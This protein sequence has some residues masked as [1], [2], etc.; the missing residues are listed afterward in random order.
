MWVKPS[1]GRYNDRCIINCRYADGMLGWATWRA[2]K[3]PKVLDAKDYWMY[4]MAKLTIVSDS[5]EHFW[6]RDIAKVP[7]FQRKNG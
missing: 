1:R 6:L 2:A 4:L 3:P 5:M 7:E